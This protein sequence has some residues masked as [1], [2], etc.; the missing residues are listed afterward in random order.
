MTL[1]F[2]CRVRN[3]GTR[4][5]AG[6]ERRASRPCGHR[7][8]R[9]PWPDFHGPTPQL[10][11]LADGDTQERCNC[12]FM[13]PDPAPVHAMAVEISSRSASVSSSVVAAIQPST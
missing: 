8:A 13:G 2:Q 9:I 5:F 1:S 11:M 4:S 7:V 6:P 3:Y 12:G 10:D